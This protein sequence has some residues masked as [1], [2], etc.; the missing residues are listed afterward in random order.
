MKIRSSDISL[1]VYDFDGV[2]T[3]NQVLVLEDG[4]E[5]VWCSRS[6]GWA[7]VQMRK[8]GMRQI[9]LSTETNRVVRARAKKLGIEVRQSIEN[10]KDALNTL[11]NE[12]GCD[13]KRVVYIGNDV[14]D[15]DAM[16]VV[17]FPLA[18]CDAH[19]KILALAKGVIPKKGGD[20][21]IR[22]FWEQIL[23]FS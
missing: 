9:I 11:C 19:E 16:G 13:L 18:P 20:G 1:I 2:F 22:Y 5:A 14:N 21:V 12:L 6:D 7:I 17:G 10:K 23:D 4:R 15:L 3:N 8:Q